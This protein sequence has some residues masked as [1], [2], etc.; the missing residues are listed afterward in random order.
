MSKRRIYDREMVGV[1]LGRLVILVVKL[2]GLASRFGVGVERTVGMV[3]I[4]GV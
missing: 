1:E 4:D 3:R 2:D